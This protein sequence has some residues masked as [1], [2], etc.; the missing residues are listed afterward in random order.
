MKIL[1]TRFQVGHPSGK[2]ICT[3][4]YHR[5]C[6]TCMV[7]NLEWVFK[8][9]GIYESGTLAA[10]HAAALLGPKAKQCDCFS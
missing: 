6:T 8:E 5:F 2:T 10:P 1:A 7:V 3:S 9:R 4:V